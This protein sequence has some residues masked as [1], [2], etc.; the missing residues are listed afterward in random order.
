MVVR[1]DDVIAFHALR[2]VGDRHRFRRR[3]MPVQALYRRAA[4]TD[5]GPVRTAHRALEHV[6]PVEHHVGLRELGLMDD[7]LV[8]AR[9]M[10]ASGLAVNQFD[11]HCPTSFNHAS[12]EASSF[13]MNV[14]K[15]VLHLE[16]NS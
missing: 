15:D 2:S 14:M 16:H 8:L 12:N 7:R 10:R 13:C 9:Y 3:D 4:R 6:T 1:A 5:G 11:G